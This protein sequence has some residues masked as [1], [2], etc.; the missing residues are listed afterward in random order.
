MGYRLSKITTKTGDS[1]ETSL[2]TGARV[3]KNSPYIEALGAVDELNCVLGMLAVKPMSLDVRRVIA[4]VQNDLFD[5]GAELSQPGRSILRSESLEYLGHQVEH[6]NA[7]LAPLEE[8][9]LPGGSESA[10]ICHFARATCRSVERVL[11]SLEDIDPAVASVRLPYLNRLSDVLFVLARVL[12]LES[13]TAEVYWS[14]PVSRTPQ[15]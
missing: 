10:A 6:F 14:S 3:Q 11:V 2:A 1:G 8:F 12:N 9:I 7:G 13:G 5:L 4:A 15:H